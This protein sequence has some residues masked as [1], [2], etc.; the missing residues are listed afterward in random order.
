MREYAPIVPKDY[1]PKISKKDLVH[2]QY[3]VGRCRNASLA[4][5]DGNREVFV[6][7]RTKFMDTFLEDIK[8]PEDD[9]LYDVFVVQ[10]LAEQDEIIE[11]P[12]D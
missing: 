1:T 9:K 7:W 8:C 11:I 2:G 10:R 4:R 12:I 5:W 3:Y 6:H